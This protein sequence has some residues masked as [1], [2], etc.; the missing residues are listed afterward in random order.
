MAPSIAR[1]ITN[2]SRNELTSLFQR[3]KTVHRNSSFDIRL[4]PKTEE[5]GRILIITPKK[6]GNAPNRNRVRRRIKALFYQEKL[7]LLPYDWIIYC[8]TKSALL[9][10]SEIKQLFASIAAAHS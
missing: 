4:A 10:F 3:A 8:K 6:M 9:S 1:R 2:F 5:I 7:Y